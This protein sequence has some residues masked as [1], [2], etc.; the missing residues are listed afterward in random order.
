MD[1]A[2]RRRVRRAL[3]RLWF[4]IGVFAGW[5]L[6]RC[7]AP[8][9]PELGIAIGKLFGDMRRFRI[10]GVEIAFH[11]EISLARDLIATL[12]GAFAFSFTN[13]TAPIE[14]VVVL[15]ESTHGQENDES[16]RRHAD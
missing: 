6:G 1:K 11:G 16:R 4:R 13:A 9:R 14:Q 8:G 5:R 7:G 12:G 2:S 15:P 3:L 10:Q